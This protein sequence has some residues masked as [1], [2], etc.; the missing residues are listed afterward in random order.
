M[1]V[2]NPEKR[3][4]LQPQRMAYCVE[5]VSSLGFEIFDQNENSFCFEYKNQKIQMFP[6]TGWH[7]GKSIKDGRGIENLLKQIKPTTTF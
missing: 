2:V 7:T 6:F 1:S 4:V 3:I 5:Q